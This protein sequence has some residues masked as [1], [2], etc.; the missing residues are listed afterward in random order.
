MSRV[1]SRWVPKL[2]TDKKRRQR[3]DVCHQLL[4][5]WREDFLNRLVTVDESWFHYYEPEWKFHSQRKRRHEP[6]PTSLSVKGPQEGEW[7]EGY[8]ANRL[9]P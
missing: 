7:A 3:V 2:M 9:P 1:V 6:T 5:S 8:S 4:K